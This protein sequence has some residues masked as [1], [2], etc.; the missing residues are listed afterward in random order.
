M[1]GVVP[2]AAHLATSVP[3]STPR[4][5]V[6][7]RPPSWIPQALL[8]FAASRVITTVLFAWVGSQATA[9]SRAGPHPSLLDLSKAWD[10][11]W[12]WY[13]AVTGYPSTLP[14]TPSGAVDTNQWAFLPVY[15]YVVKALSLGNN[16]LWPTT[17][18]VVSLICA[19][20]AG[21]LLG[22]LLRHRLDHAQTLFAV[23]VFSVSPL[24]FLFQTGYAESMGL[25]LLLGALCLLDRRHYLAA[26]PLAVVLAFTRPGALALSLT[27]GVGMLV[28]LIA[29]RRNGPPVAAREV[30]SAAVFCVVAILAGVAWPVIAG[31][32]TGVPDAYLAT[33][34]AWRSLWMPTTSFAFFTPWLFAAHFWFTDA[35]GVILAELIVAFGLL[36]FTPAVRR[37]GSTI[38]I[39]SG[40]YVLYLLAA[41]FPQSSIFRLLMPLAPL[42]G[43]VAVPRRPAYRIGVLS[44][45][46][47]L[48][49]LWLW[50][51]YGPFQAYWSV[52]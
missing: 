20:G 37:L 34:A 41:F 52:P 35:G 50:C 16:G 22:V 32:A 14:R 38:R 43:A 18:V 6:L 12:Y 26:T 49:A 15:P 33:E 7:R 1:T 11:T 44:A 8:I 47:A 10:A 19:A 23:A 42:T 25:L 40:S 36:L 13:I 30:G 46:V 24:S 27:V 21:L 3:A 39:W 48:Q 29:A 5:G 51:T 9:A 4:H 28:R 31:L 17:A 45:C 2:Q